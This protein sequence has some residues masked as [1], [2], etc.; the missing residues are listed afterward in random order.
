MSSKSVITNS[1]RFKF[2]EKTEEEVGEST[3]YATEITV[4]QLEELYYRV[5]DAEF[6]S[7]KVSFTSYNEEEETF[8]EFFGVNFV[9]EAGDNF[10]DAGNDENEEEYQYVYYYTNRSYNIRDELPMSDDFKAFLQEPY[11]VPSFFDDPVKYRDASDDERILW[12]QGAV[13]FLFSPVYYPNYPNLGLNYAFTELDFPTFLGF[14]EDYSAYVPCVTAFSFEFYLEQESME[15]DYYGFEAIN[16]DSSTSTSPNNPNDG[17]FFNEI[18]ADIHVSKEVAWVDLDGSKNPFSSGNKL[19]IPVH[20]HMGAYGGGFLTLTS[21][22]V[23]KNYIGEVDIDKYVCDLVFKMNSGEVKTPILALDIFPDDGEITGSD[24]VMEATE[25]W[26]Y[27][28]TW[29]ADTGEKSDTG[30]SSS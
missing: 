14:E 4:D 6:T 3:I 28:G 17:S 29:D 2:V 20:F 22:L 25:W 26:P 12:E 7:G 5:K 18:S 19:Y 11:E 23:Y 8:E 13:D 30:E 10:M 27:N 9:G 1:Y 16:S 15:I 21:P 24:F